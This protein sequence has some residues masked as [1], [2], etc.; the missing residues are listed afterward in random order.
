MVDPIVDTGFAMFS[1]RAFRAGAAVPRTT[2]STSPDQFTK[3]K[4]KR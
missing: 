2:P 4:D 1:A 3:R